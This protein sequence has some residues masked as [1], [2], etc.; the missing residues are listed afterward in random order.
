[1]SEGQVVGL[2]ELWLPVFHI[3]LLCIIDVDLVHRLLYVFVPSLHHDVRER[4]RSDRHGTVFTV[5]VIRRRGGLHRFQRLSLVRRWT[6]EVRA[7]L[8]FVLAFV[9]CV[10]RTLNVQQKVHLDVIQLVLTDRQ[11][12]IIRLEHNFIF[13]AKFT[14]FVHVIENF[15]LFLDDEGPLNLSLPFLLEV[16]TLC[17]EADIVEPPCSYEFLK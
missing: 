9:V 7:L 11:D 17:I 14:L 1:M 5:G 8:L 16:L 10:S 15:V 4:F 2:C 3:Q 12:Q 13:V 6:R